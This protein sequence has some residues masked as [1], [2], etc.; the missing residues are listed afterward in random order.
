MKRRTVAF[1]LSAFIVIAAAIQFIR[2]ER[3]NPPVESKMTFEAASN[4]SPET[5]T[6]LR[7]SC[8]D[9]HSNSTN[10]PWYSHV[11]PVSWLVADDVKEGRRHLNLSQWGRLSKEEAQAK[12]EEICDEVRAGEMPLWIYTLMHKEARLSQSDKDILCNLK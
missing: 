3:T 4:L 9:C 2:P 8:A 12:Q 10:W 5:V 11:A 1:G 7:R 6:I